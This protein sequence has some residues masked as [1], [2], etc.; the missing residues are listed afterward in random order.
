[1]ISH[2]GGSLKNPVSR[3]ACTHL[4]SSVHRSSSPLHVGR[5]SQQAQE[6]YRTHYE[7]A[8]F[9]TRFHS[10]SQANKHPHP[11]IHS[12]CA[13]DA[14]PVKFRIQI[15]SSSRLVTSQFCAAILPSSIRALELLS[16]IM[17]VPLCERNR[18]ARNTAVAVLT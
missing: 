10:V 12:S 14:L 5:E 3:I 6:P 8:W 1:M 16:I 4:S 18:C 17:S 9:E 15:S 7:A 2:S 11:N 13:H